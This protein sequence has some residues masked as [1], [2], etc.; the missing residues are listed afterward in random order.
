MKNILVP[1]DFSDNAQNAFVYALHIAHK[2]GATL[3]T[4]HTYT[5]RYYTPSDTDLSAIQDMLENEVDIEFEEYKAATE[6]LRKIAEEL[7]FGEV[8]MNHLLRK[9]FVTE[10]ILDVIAGEGIDLIVMGTK[11]ASGLKE[12]IMGSNTA[13]VIENATCPVLAIPQDAKFTNITKVVYATNCDEHD[14]LI[15]E[16]V[17]QFAQLFNAELNCIHISFID[18]AWDKEKLKE[19]EKL[20]QQAK[21]T[22]SLNF[23]VIE[24]ESVI[25]GLKTYAKNNQVSVI[26]MHTHKRNFFERIFLASYTQ[27]MA[28]HTHLPL[29]SFAF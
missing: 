21:Q 24:S 2:L 8:N 3:T 28:Y 12:V 14:N 7:G 18:E 15:I 11:G 29:L 19:F 6:K 5:V 23:E 13:K 27:K 25:D 9:G 20:T 26:A 10:E 16:R 22:P 1:T 17:Y 4:L